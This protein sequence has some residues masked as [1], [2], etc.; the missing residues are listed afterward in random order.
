MIIYLSYIF[1]LGMPYLAR[2]MTVLNRPILEIRKSGRDNCWTIYSS[3]FI[4][5]TQVTFELG[6]EY[7]EVCFDNNWNTM[8]V[9][10]KMSLLP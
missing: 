1:H 10:F 9:I 8:E 6:K 3:S 5:K 7:E 2:K 4:R